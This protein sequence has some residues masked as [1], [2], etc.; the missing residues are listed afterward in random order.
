[1]N[2]LLGGQ[3]PLMFDS[4]P[5]VLPQLRTGRLKALGVTSLKGVPLAPEIPTIDESGV[6]G[7]EAIAWFG[8]YGP[9]RMPAE[10]TRRVSAEVGAALNSA[11]IKEQFAKLGAEPGT[12]TQPEFAHF[13]SAEMEKWGKLIERAH[14]TV[15]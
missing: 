11:Q 10:L 7:F 13:V 8:L 15:D 2:D 9:A 6:K 1:M 4:L 5:T 12:L 3:I 14:I